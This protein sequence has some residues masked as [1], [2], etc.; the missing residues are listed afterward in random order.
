MADK[1]TIKVYKWNIVG[2]GRRPLKLDIGH[3]LSF[4]KI[5]LNYWNK[6][7][8]PARA[9][10]IETMY[11]SGGADCGATLI[12]VDELQF[13][14]ESWHLKAGCQFC[15]AQL[16]AT[17]R[18]HKVKIVLDEGMSA[19]TKKK[20]KLGAFAGAGVIAGVCAIPLALPLLGFT[21]AGVAAGSIA[22]SIQSVVYGGFTGGLF[23]LAQSAGAAGVGA[24]TTAAMGAAGGAAGA[25]A[26]AMK[27][28]DSEEKKCPTKCTC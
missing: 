28:S 15:M 3:E 17:F 19:E 11:L 13:K 9:S 2:Y 18:Q 12:I 14:L 16:L 24:A 25:A 7:S 5:E 27:K 6:T 10:S 22:A 20:L 21:S 26:V 1:C 8:Y 23:S 4:V